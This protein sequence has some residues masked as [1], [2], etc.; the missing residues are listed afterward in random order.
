MSPCR[1][2]LQPPLPSRHASPPSI[3]GSAPTPS[4]P[5]GWPAF[6]CARHYYQ[7]AK[8]RAKGKGEGAAFSPGRDTC[9]RDGITKGQD[10]KHSPGRHQ[11][12]PHSPFFLPTASLCARVLPWRL[13]SRTHARG[14]SRVLRGTSAS[15]RR[16]R[17]APCSQADSLF[18]VSLLR[19]LVPLYPLSLKMCGIFGKHQNMF[20]HTLQDAACRPRN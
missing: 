18:L 17:L 1:P 2:R 9:A 19:A 5:A 16:A 7:R 8:R 3:S 13:E 12:N 14:S 4:L 11:N 10:E 20:K 15:S 6:L